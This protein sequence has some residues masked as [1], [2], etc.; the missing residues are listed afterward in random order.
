MPTGKENEWI[1]ELV[2]TLWGRKKFSC[3]CQESKPCHPTRIPSLYRLL[4]AIAKRM[5]V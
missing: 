3:P 4:E 1:P 2:W 5:K